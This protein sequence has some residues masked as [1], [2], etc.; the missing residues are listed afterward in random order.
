[1]GCPSGKVPLT[2]TVTNPV[3]VGSI[4]GMS[5]LNAFPNPTQDLVT[6]DLD[7]GP[8]VLDLEMSVM[9]AQGRAVM[10]ERWVGQTSGLRAVDFGSL[11]P[12]VYTVRLTD[13]VGQWRLPV[14]RN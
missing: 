12:G 1:V 11:A 9:D 14:M 6:L 10:F 5:D 2:V 8:N 13:G 7:L 3:G 4:E